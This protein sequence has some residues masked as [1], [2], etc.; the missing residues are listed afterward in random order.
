MLCLHVRI[1]DA[2]LRHIILIATATSPN[3]TSTRCPKKNTA[4]AS[5]AIFLVSSNE[6]RVRLGVRKAKARLVAIGKANLPSIRRHATQKRQ[7]RGNEQ[8]EGR[9]GRGQFNS[10]LRLLI[11]LLR[12]LSPLTN[13]VKRTT[14]FC[15]H[16]FLFSCVDSAQ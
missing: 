5:V 1:W 16:H 8:Q 12:E 11:L 10:F 2:V 13:L 9:H 3:S 6:F 14:R 4:E 15:L 7:Q